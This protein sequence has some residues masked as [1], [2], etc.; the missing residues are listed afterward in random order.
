MGRIT[1]PSPRSH[2]PRN[3]A[4]FASIASG[5]FKPANSPPCSPTRSKPCA[6]PI[7]SMKPSIHCRFHDRPRRAGE[8]AFTL[9]ELM[10]SVTI[11]I[12]LVG[13]VVSTNLFGLRMFQIEEIKLNSTDEA[14]KIV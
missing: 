6:G 12:L 9:T 3:C 11:F 13:G 2:L 5:D 1:P 10:V 4:A 14:S 7:E 8:L